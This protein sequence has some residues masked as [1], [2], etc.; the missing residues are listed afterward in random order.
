MKR[1]S[2]ISGKIYFKDPYV[3]GSEIPAANIEC[4]IRIDHLKNGSQRSTF[5]KTFHTNN[6]GSFSVTIELG[7]T[8]DVVIEMRTEMNGDY[9][10]KLYKDNTTIKHKYLSIIKHIKHG[11]NYSDYKISV[12][13]ITNPANEQ[14][15]YNKDDFLKALSIMTACRLGY[16]QINKF[17][18]ITK[19]PVIYF[20]LKFP[21]KFDSR[22][23]GKCIHIKDYVKAEEEEKKKNKEKMTDQDRLFWW[24]WTLK[25]IC[26]EFGHFVA[27]CNGFMNAS[28]G[29]HNDSTNKTEER[30]NKIHGLHFAWNEGFAEFFAYYTINRNPDF[31]K[32]FGPDYKRTIKK[33]DMTG[34]SSESS[35]EKFLSLM[36]FESDEVGYQF[37]TEKKF[38]DAL[39]TDKPKRID[40]CIKSLAKKNS[41]RDRLGK[42]L[43]ASQIAPYN[44]S[45]DKKAISFKNTG[46]DN[47]LT[48]LNEFVFFIKTSGM[49]SYSKFKAT[50]NDLS[51]T[52]S[53]C[54]YTI[55]DT[56][57]LNR[58]NKGEALQAYIDGYQ[59]DRINSG[60]YTS[61]LHGE[62]TSDGNDSSSSKELDPTFSKVNVTVNVADE[63]GARTNS[64][65]YFRVITKNGNAYPEEDKDAL[66]DIEHKN[67]FKRGS[68]MTYGVYLGEYIHAK[69]LKQ[70]RLSCNFSLDSQKFI[71]SKIIVK[72]SDNG[73]ILAEYNKRTIIKKNKPLEIALDAEKLLKKYE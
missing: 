22:N 2:K 27:Y 15:N 55:K 53:K 20:P 42:I 24:R 38:W 8:E 1:S 45:F 46:T 56:N 60:P 14:L 9:P 4:G 49:S 16:Q 39:K 67:D 51:V 54:K 21:S 71:I 28:L 59:T 69:D 11:Q 13:D 31:K 43:S 37:L 23:L 58:L 61:E 48:K 30:N 5:L 7:N 65:V 52:T 62:K 50:L 57:I 29:T 70:F 32:Y 41:N 33:G 34:E 12:N 26:H 36:T 25:T 64:D 40:D 47:K 35:V 17:Y 66:L 63:V 19:T 72:D 3:N 6:D 68:S 10:V 18:N 73:V 44:L